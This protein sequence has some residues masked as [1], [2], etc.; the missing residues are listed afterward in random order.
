M[1]CLVRTDKS[2]TKHEGISFLLLD[3]ASPGVRVRPISL[4][5]GSSH[6]CET[7]FDEV[8]VPKRNL[9]GKPGGGWTIAKAVLEHER[10]IISRMRDQR[11]DRETPLEE[12]LAQYGSDPLLRDRVAQANIDFLCNALTLKRS[13]EGRPGAETSMFKLYGTELSKRRRVLAVEIAGYQALG[14]EGEGF[15]ADELSRTRDWLRSRASSIE[16]GTS[17]IQLNI[18]AK[19]VLGL[20]D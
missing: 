6:F 20:P 11:M 10:S 4:I 14:W 15:S 12:L 1:F 18:I 5:S 9:V 16:G 13:R 2:A 17:E 8:R 7:F 19:R 3:M